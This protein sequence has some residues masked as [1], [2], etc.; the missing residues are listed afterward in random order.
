MKD[1]LRTL[2][3]CPVWAESLEI[4]QE[5]VRAFHRRCASILGGSCGLRPLEERLLLPERNL[6][7][8]LFIA[9]AKSLG[10]SDAKVRFYAMV[11]Q[12]IRALV[13]GCDNLLDDEY[14][15]VIPFDLPGDGT[16][17]RSVLMVMT[18]DR[19]LSELAAKMM[20]EGRFSLAQANRL[21]RTAVRVLMP[22]GLEEH[23]EESGAA[24][25]VPTP[26]AICDD[27]HYR[28]TG[29]LFEAPLSLIEEMGD[30]YAGQTRCAREAL[31]GLGLACQALDDIKDI[32]RDLQRGQHNAVVSYAYYG[33]SEA[34]R[35]LLLSF[36]RPGAG[37]LPSPEHVAAGLITAR[38]RTFAHAAQL[39]DEV[40]TMLCTAIPGF[41]KEHAVALTG[42]IRGTLGF[43]PDPVWRH[44]AKQEILV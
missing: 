10:L 32:A 17:F 44:A 42:A 35:G 8:T 39:F 41:E 31:S 24:R 40:E 22:S 36:L 25:T 2:A 12:C 19:V 43:D 4:Q 1:A 14:K 20:H 5:T 34:E 11:N 9:A 13:T 23:E 27:V 21:M 28:K 29:L 18:A 38:S 30:A 16:R 6:F 7:S 33:G 26:E 15:E 3:G 37:A